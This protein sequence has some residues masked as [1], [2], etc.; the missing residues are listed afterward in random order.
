MFSPF[1]ALRGPTI[2]AMLARMAIVAVALVVVLAAVRIVGQRVSSSRYH[3]AAVTEVARIQPASRLLTDMLNA[4]T[5]VQ[6]YITTIDPFRQYALQEALLAFGR[7]ID[8]GRKA[9]TDAPEVEERLDRLNTLANEWQTVNF[10]AMTIAEI[11]R[12][13]RALKMTRG[14]LNPFIREH[15]QLM[16]L[17]QERRLD[18][19]SQADH[20]G[21]ISYWISNAAIGLGGLIL[22][23]FA[24]RIARRV[25]GPLGSL[26][27]AAKRIG[28]GRL[29][30]PVPVHP[31]KDE[32][33]DLAEAFNAMELDLAAARRQLEARAAELEEAN[34]L[35]GE[36]V[37]NVSHELRTPLSSIIGYSQLLLDT[38]HHE[39][40]E[41]QHSD[42]TTILTAAE[43]LLVLIH[44]VLDM[45]RIDAGQ[46][47]VSPQQ[48]DARELA[49]EA[50]QAVATL[51]HAKGLAL[52]QELPDEP[53]PAFCDP[54][55]V[56]QVLLNLLGNAVKFTDTGA[57]TVRVES[58]GPWGLMIVR[59]TGP[60]IPEDEIA[61][62]WQEFRQVDGSLTRRRGG[63]G[64]GLAITRH[65]VG[66]Q[67]GTITCESEVGVGSTFTVALPA[68]GEAG[69]GAPASLH[70]RPAPPGAR[71]LVVEDNPDTARLM[72]RWLR[73]AGYQPELADSAEAALRALDAGPPPDC[74]VLDL[75]LPGLDGLG[76]LSR[77]RERPDAAEIPV[78]ITSMLDERARG[79]ALG[80]TDY[81]TK[82]VDRAELLMAV[83]RSEATIADHGVLVVDDD[84][85][86]LE[87]MVRWLTP[88]GPVH[89]ARD[90]TEGLALLKQLRP[91]AA[92]VDLMMPGMSGLEL[93]RAA[94]EDPALTATSIIAVSAKILT[95][96][97]ALELQEAAV[98]MLP[99]AGL[100][101]EALL[102]E[103]SRQLMRPRPTTAGV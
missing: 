66:L 35:K 40:T 85:A 49:R 38:D 93:I 42:V 51:A 65:L 99:K 14:T 7:G 73:G 27:A 59:D 84:P 44:D 18:A 29:G 23:F 32:I 103:V 101:R 60:G 100:A 33:H 58:S 43:H 11:G 62:I 64:L 45:A 70:A 22:I 46:L 63:T 57:V 67:G 82:P 37:A 17:L 94:R 77:L 19:V 92:V 54:G 15:R 102:S 80:A 26:Q 3:Q 55:R 10:R 13:V 25:L 28:Q 50:C 88:L 4:Q 24:V 30:E 12:T 78:V 74:I 8:A 97:E 75:I 81:L 2:R 61:G 87:L 69:N 1:R 52:V 48:Q 36:F 6:G 86:A 89:L 21:A 76:L 91:A 34:R 96:D 20:W 39:L 98:A 53:V 56:R 5:A 16:T 79:L 31:Q 68:H 90:G 71:V 47:E 95:A 83:E 9:N 41:E 72:A